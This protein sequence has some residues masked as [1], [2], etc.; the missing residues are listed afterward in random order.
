MNRRLMAWSL[1]G[2]T[3]AAAA[4]GV[5]W[6]GVSVVAPSITTAHSPAIP[7]R[8][9][10]QELVAPAPPERRASARPLC[11]AAWL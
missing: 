8:E 3:T 7:E 9:V 6:A 2:L 11:S 1:W 4:T 10:H 5:S